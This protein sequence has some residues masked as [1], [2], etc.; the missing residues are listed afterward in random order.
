M[1]SRSHVRRVAGHGFGLAS[2][3]PDQIADHHLAARN[4]D[5]GLEHFAIAQLNLSHSRNRIETC[6]YGPLSLV[7]ES[8]RPA[9]I[10][11]QAIAEILRHMPTV[12]RDAA[13]Y[14]I[15]IGP[16]D[17]AKIFGIEATGELG[18]TDEVTKHDGELSSFDA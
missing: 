9:K 14:G 1:Q 6:P 11:Q 12:T 4:T 7:F 17:L 3:F 15:L 8:L 16:H 10:N 2:G 18:R 13:R 5:A